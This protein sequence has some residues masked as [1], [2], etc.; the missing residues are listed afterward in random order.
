MHVSYKPLKQNV[1]VVVIHY[2]FTISRVEWYLRVLIFISLIVSELEHLFMCLAILYL[3]VNRSCLFVI[4]YQLSF[5]IYEFSQVLMDIC[6]KHAFSVFNYFL[7]LLMVFFGHIKWFVIT[8][9]QFFSIS[10]GFW[11]MAKS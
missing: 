1:V 4:F 5:N 11:V 9:M 8:F 7:T 2:N 3:F 10:F 6:K